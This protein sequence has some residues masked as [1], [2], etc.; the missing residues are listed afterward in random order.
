LI[1]NP[2]RPH[3]VEPRVKKRRPKLFPL[4]I[5]SRQELRQQ[6]VQQELSGSL[7]AIRVRPGIW[8]QSCDV[9][10]QDDLRSRVVTYSPPLEAACHRR[11]RSVWLSWRMDET[12]IRVRGEWRDLYRAVDSTGQTID[13]LLMEQRDE[14]AARIAVRN[15]VPTPHPQRRAEEVVK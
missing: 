6:L 7:H 11:K 8:A 1:V 12:Y 3:R 13:V 14:R 15:R 10:G 9:L 2:I 4:M 5:K